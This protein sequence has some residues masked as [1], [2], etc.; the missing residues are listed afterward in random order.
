MFDMILFLNKIFRKKARESGSQIIKV[1][2]LTVTSINLCQILS[3]FV[4]F[5]SYYSIPVEA[6]GLRMIEDTQIKTPTF[7]RGLNFLTF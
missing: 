3:G 7:R 2:L 6:I 5:Q 1:T 4:V